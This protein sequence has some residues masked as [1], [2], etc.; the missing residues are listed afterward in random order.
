MDSVGNLDKF[1][2]SGMKVTQ[3]QCHECKHYD[4]HLSCPAFPEGI[5]SVILMNEISHKKPL[6]GDNGITFT[7]K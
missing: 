2:A 1:D 5:P 3:P 4:G 7:P 6:E